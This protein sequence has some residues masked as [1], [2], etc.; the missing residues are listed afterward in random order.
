MAD[1]SSQLILEALGRAALE[2]DGVALIAARGE[3]GLFQ[4]TAA[5]KALAD[6]CREEG[7]LIL[8]RSETQGKVTRDICQITEKG[9]LHLVREVSPKHLL[10]DF[11]RV[12]ESR[13]DEIDSLSGTLVRMQE[14]LGGMRTVLSQVLPRLSPN[15]APPAPAN[16]P[17]PAALAAQARGRTDSLISAV[18]SQL[19]EWHATAGAS[20]DCPLP[21]LYKCVNAVSTLSVGEFHD[22]LRLLY[23][24]NRVWL[25]PWTGPLYALPE[26]AL[27]LLVGHEIA[28][29]G[30]LR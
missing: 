25:H 4:A 30:S 20:Q 9:M 10:E 22:I 13:Q 8:V 14:S 19:A 23:A 26:P 12:L 21:Q 2:P 3:G 15:S 29:Y 6:R 11:L 1:R 28:Y 27:A 16:A 7:W 5:S 17:T 24:D 18:E